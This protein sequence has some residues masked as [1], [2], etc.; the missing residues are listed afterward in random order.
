MGLKLE[1]WYYMISSIFATMEQMG[2]EPANSQA[3]VTLHN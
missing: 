3:Y 1:V 2:S